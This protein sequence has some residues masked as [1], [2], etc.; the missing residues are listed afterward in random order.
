MAPLSEDPT[1]SLVE[2]KN[3]YHRYLPA[4]SYV[5]E[6][7][8]LE[9]AEGD[10]V[11]LIGP[12]GCGKSTLLKLI[13]GLTEAERGTLDIAG[14]SPDE[15]RAEQAFVFQDAT[16]LPWLTVR[17]NVELPMQ[18]RNTKP[19]I[20]K[21]RALELLEMV[22]LSHVSD[23]FPRQL[24]G[25]MKMRTSIA[26]ALSLTPKI[27]L[28][29]EP[30]GALD[31][32][33]RDKLNEDLLDIRKEESW[34]AFFVTHSVTEATFLSNKIAVFSANPGRI[35]KVIE[36][37]FSYPRDSDMRNSMEFHNVVC[38]VSEQLREAQQ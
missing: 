33:T 8:N 29:D 14:K 35:Q 16:L 7:L 17:G 5:L 23:N 10:F 18:L 1:K 15:A 6:G 22:R 31:E 3:V 34:T 30:F 21:K 32:M 28:L 2:I 11:A 36:V 37:P 20:R 25:G 12:S 9:V 24:S 38:E 19:E 26:R 13:S 4:G 27:M